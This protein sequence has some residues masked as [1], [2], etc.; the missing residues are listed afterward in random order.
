MW[1]FPLRHRYSGFSG[2]TYMQS[3]EDPKLWIA[4]TRIKYT[5]AKPAILFF[6][7]HVG[8]LQQLPMDC[9]STGMYY[10]G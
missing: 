5:F 1:L 4:M 6:S 10:Q 3:P 8:V 2:S 7:N 9:L